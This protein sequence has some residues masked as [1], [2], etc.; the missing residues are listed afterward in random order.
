M[1]CPICGKKW[2]IEKMSPHCM[3]WAYC[4]PWQNSHALWE[5]K[6][7][8][9]AAVR[10]YLHCVFHRRHHLEHFAKEA[11]SLLEE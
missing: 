4:P 6:F 11:A 3:C 5:S 8:V 1:K 2:V 7:R 10:L 9:T